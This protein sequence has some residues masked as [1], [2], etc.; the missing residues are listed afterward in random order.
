M[1]KLEVILEFMARY[2]FRTVLTEIFGS[3]ANFFV[4]IPNYFI[5]SSDNALGVVKY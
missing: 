4:V 1:K 2:F 3:K 5:I